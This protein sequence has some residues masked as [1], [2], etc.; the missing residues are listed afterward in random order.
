M[1]TRRWRA[2]AFLATCLVVVILGG[3]V[4][5]AVLSGCTLV[6]IEGDGNTISDTGGHGGGL[7]MPTHTNGSQGV[8]EHFKG[9]AQGQ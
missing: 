5:A 9:R 1:N 2:P 6:Y 3:L 8:L 4:I 7:A